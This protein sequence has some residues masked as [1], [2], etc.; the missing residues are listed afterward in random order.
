MNSTAMPG[1]SSQIRSAT[2]RPCM[3]GIT[4]SVTST[5]SGSGEPVT[6]A[7]ASAP[8]AAAVTW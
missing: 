1:C 3:P 5:S 7:I 4:T 2:S 8:L 6:A